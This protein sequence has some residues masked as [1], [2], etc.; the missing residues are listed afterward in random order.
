LTHESGSCQLLRFALGTDDSKPQLLAELGPDV[1]FI[2]S[3]AVGD[4]DGDGRDEI[5]AGTRPN[6]QVLLLDTGAKGLEATVIDEA[7]YGWQTTNTREVV[8]ADADGDGR[9]EILAA[10]A[11]IDADKWGATPGS[12]S[13]YSRS[14]GDRSGG[15]WTKRVLDDFAGVSHSR[16]VAVGRL[17]SD[18][19]P[20]LVANRVGVYQSEGERIDPGTELYLYRVAG[21]AIERESIGPLDGAIK[22]RGFAI[23]DVDGD[24]HNELVVGTRALDIP[25]HGETSLAILKWNPFRLRWSRETLAKS[26]PLGFHCVAVADVDGDG[27]AEIIASDDGTGCIHL[28]AQ[29]AAGWRRHALV[30]TA[31]RIFVVNIQVVA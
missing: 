7:E 19:R 20:A 3:L 2:R 5:V 17:G 30:A 4:V 22:S 26:G 8:I 12:V 1:S 31:R 25:G 27:R 6:G 21:Q 11:R 13:L 18:G 28:Y 24:G 10:V 9:L 16:M 15:D 14:V 29:D 23:G